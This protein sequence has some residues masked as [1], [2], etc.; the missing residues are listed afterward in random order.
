MQEAVD[1]IAWDLA[2]C[3]GN[4][5]IAICIAPAYDF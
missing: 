2:N 1:F 5:Q 4:K 3:Q